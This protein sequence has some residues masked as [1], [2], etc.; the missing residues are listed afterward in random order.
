MATLNSLS[1]L[2]L[3]TLRD[4]HSA[5]DQITSAL[6]KMAEAATHPELRQAFE[7]HVVQSKE[8]MKRVEE[9]A[10]ALGKSA[11]GQKCKGMQGLIEEGKEI[12]KMSG[13]P[14]VKDAALIGAAQRVEHYEIA[15][16]GCAKTYARLLGREQD[17]RLL[18]Q[19]A[20][21]EG[22]T[23]KLLTQ[24]AERVV[25]RDALQ[26]MPVSR[27]A[28]AGADIRQGQ[29]TTSGTASSTTSSST[30][31]QRSASD[32]GSGQSSTSER[33]RSATDMGGSRPSMDR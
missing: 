2:Y 23:D 8:H 25:N 15:A 4:I 7:N 22:E 21:E 5:E 27:T 1:D 10:S 14:D 17:V 16:Y 6:P 9:I 28:A 31:R 26:D 20:D 24:L 30:E 12:L 33:Q 13:E 19:T 29:R 11:K 18:Q 3:H 32:M